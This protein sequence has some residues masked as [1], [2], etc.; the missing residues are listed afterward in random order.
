MILFKDEES[1]RTRP[2]PKL[3]TTPFQKINT[4]I[5]EQQVLLSMFVVAEEKSV[6]IL[7]ETHRSDGLQPFNPSSKFCP[8]VG[9]DDYITALK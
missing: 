7:S 1:L 3:G 2:N 8:L 5:R 6:Y 9:P 4:P